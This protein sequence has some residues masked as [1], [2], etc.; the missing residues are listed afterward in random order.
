MCF[1]RGSR[2]NCK[3]RVL[4]AR[5]SQVTATHPA[6]YDVQLIWYDKYKFTIDSGYNQYKFT[7]D[8]GHVLLICLNLDSKRFQNQNV[9]TYG[10]LR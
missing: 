5:H 6:T 10:N 2:R 7:I 1:A 9:A 3:V 4:R 8:S